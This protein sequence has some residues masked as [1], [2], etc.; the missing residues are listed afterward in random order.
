MLAGLTTE[1]FFDP[2]ASS[3]TGEWMH[4]FKPEIAD[5][6][7]L[8]RLIRALPGSIEYLRDHAA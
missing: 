1:D 8:L 6:H 2:R 4:V 3:R 5:M 7:M